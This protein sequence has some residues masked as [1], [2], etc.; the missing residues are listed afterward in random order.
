VIEK[1]DASGLLERGNGHCLSM[2]DMIQKILL[3]KGVDCE[4]VECSLMITIKD[5]PS[6]A[7]IGYDGMSAGVIDYS[8]K[9]DNQ[10][11]IVG[12]DNTWEP[13]YDLITSQDQVQFYEMVMGDVNGNRTTVLERADVM[14]KDNRLTPIGFSVNH[15][16]YDT[17]KIVGDALYDPNFNH[18]PNGNEGSGTDQIR[19]H[20]PLNGFSGNL[21][22]TARLMYQTVPPK[23]LEEMFTFDNEAINSFRSMY[24]AEGA[25]PVQVGAQ[26]L[27]CTIVGVEEIRIPTF[28]LFPNPT[29]DGWVNLTSN[30][31][32]VDEI[33]IYSI[34]GRFIERRKIGSVVADRQSVV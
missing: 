9:M 3:Q 16:S 24:D 28:L 4:L 17:T 1:L 23:Y 15:A 2:S 27:M 22:V 25:D 6:M 5:P 8:G 26:T 33:A 11:R 7:L 13:H 30:G 18:F 20:I 14:L 34:D 21:H 29:S 19:V 10:Y 31:A 12:E 32:I